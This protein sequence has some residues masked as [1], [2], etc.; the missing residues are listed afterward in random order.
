M[1]HPSA[2]CAGILALLASLA[3]DRA[4]A[5]TVALVH[6]LFNVFGTLVFYPVPQM[7]AIPLRLATGLATVPQRR[8]RWVAIYV[9]GVFI[10]P[11]V[12]GVLLLH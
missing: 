4:E 3:T 12:A 11:P 10:V 6:S 1:S 5:L 9:V 2:V 7:R 8:K